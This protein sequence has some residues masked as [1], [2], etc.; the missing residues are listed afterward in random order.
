MILNDFDAYTAALKKINLNESAMPIYRGR[1]LTENVDIYCKIQK[2]LNCPSMEQCHRWLYDLDVE[3][4]DESECGKVNNL[5]KL[6]IDN[7]HIDDETDDTEMSQEDPVNSD[8]I[9]PV[10]DPAPT[11]PGLKA[12]APAMPAAPAPAPVPEVP[13]A[14]YTIVYSATRDGEIKTGEA[15]SN[16]I[17][18]R[19]AKADVIGKLEKAGY[20]NISILAIEAGDPDMSG[21]DNTFCKQTDYVQPTYE[22]KKDELE[23]ADDREPLANSMKKFGYNASTANSIGQDAVQMNITEDE[24][25]AEVKKAFDEANKQVKA[26]PLSEMDFTKWLKDNE[27]NLTVIREKLTG[28]AIKEFDDLLKFLTDY[29]AGK[30]PSASFGEAKTNKKPNSGIDTLVRG[31]FKV[32]CTLVSLSGSAVGLT[33]KAVEWAGNIITTSADKVNLMVKDSEQAP[34]KVEEAGDE[35]DATDEDAPAD[36]EAAADEKA[37]DKAEDKPAD[38]EKE[39]KK[40]ETAE[41]PDE[42]LKDDKKDEEGKADPS[43]DK[44]EKDLSDQEKSQLKDSYKKAFKAAIQKCKFVEKSFDVLTLEEKVKFFTE[45]EKAWGTKAD[46][47]KFMSDKELEQLEMIVIK[48]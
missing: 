22:E 38:E 24:T 6:G 36:E 43:D 37:D 5:F 14:A 41:E 10:T 21:C 47:S 39:D 2:L 44:K 25:Q 7:G 46:P 30:L 12:P 4:L 40:E 26:T 13:M 23:E 11:M 48:K 16:S 35:E 9:L 15:Y 32:L 1:I 33:G 45:L 18:T 3:N 8:M 27:K 20:Q 17:N 31:V 28:K 29:A 34:E 19:S 42:K